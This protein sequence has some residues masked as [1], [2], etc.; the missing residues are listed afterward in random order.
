[1]NEP[2]LS[3]VVP[4]YEAAAT[5]EST[6]RS[7]LAQTRG[8]FEL[9]VVDDGSRDDTS[10]RVAALARTDDRIRLLRRPNQGVAAARNAGV[11]AARGEHVSFLDSDDLWLPDY[12]AAMTSALAARPEAGFAYTDAW[13]LDERTRRIHRASMMAS[14]EPPVV[15]PDDPGELLRLLIRGNFVF[16]SA[17][18]RRAVLEQTGG[19]RAEFSPAEDY[20]LWLR[21]VARGYAA[22]RVPGRL[23]VY[24][25]RSGSL[26]SDPATL[27]E[28]ERRVY[29]AVVENGGLDDDVRAV[30]AERLHDCE[31]RLAELRARREPS[32]GRRLLSRA[33]WAL[34]WR[35][36]YYSRPP[37]E[38]ARAFPDLTNV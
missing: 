16:T 15:A 25:D 23:A 7:V 37:T 38:V 11:E 36:T 6:I 3:V 13:I 27:Y 33:K 5:I 17:T 35:R 29:A 31:R 21:I 19:F 10:G 4:A 20:D 32:T 26:S 14:R 1:M 28:A 12:L 34:L 2:A 8:D 22:V 30:A 24:R 18:V 9:I